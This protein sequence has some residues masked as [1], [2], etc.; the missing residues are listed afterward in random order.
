MSAIL[1]IIAFMCLQPMESIRELLSEPGSQAWA[2]QRL[3]DGAKPSPVLLLLIKGTT[4]RSP[5]ALSNLPK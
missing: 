5:L 3:F 1:T 2:S 4:V